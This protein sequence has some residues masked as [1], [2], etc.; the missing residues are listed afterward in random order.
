MIPFTHAI[1]DDE[2]SVIRKYRWSAK[3]A[4]WH[5]E[6]GKKVVKLEVEKTTKLTPYQEA[7]E[8]VGECLV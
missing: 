7:W 2:G 6:Q 1:V 5:K 3:E 8:L 4:K